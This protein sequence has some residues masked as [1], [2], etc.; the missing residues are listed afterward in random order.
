MSLFIRRKIAVVD[1]HIDDGNELELDSVAIELDLIAL[2]SA[3][4]GLSAEQEAEVGREA[5]RARFAAESIRRE[6]GE[7]TPRWLLT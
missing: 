7:A 1:A 3:S 6:R 2:H 4:H 5:N